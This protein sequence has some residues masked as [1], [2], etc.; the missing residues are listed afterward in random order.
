MRF[1]PL[2]QQSEIDR[3]LADARPRL[4]RAPSL[5]WAEAMIGLSMLVLLQSVG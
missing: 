1:P 5:P 4:R 3:R 2:A